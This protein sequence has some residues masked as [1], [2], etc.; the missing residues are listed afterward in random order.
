[1]RAFLQTLIGLSFFISGLVF[2]L[3]ESSVLRQNLEEAKHATNA[4]TSAQTE[5]IHTLQKILDLIEQRD[6]SLKEA[7]QYQT[8]IDRFPILSA[9][10]RQTLENKK[11]SHQSVNTSLSITQLEQEIVRVSSQSLAKA[12]L[13]QQEQDLIR[14]INNSVNQLP[15]QLA[16]AKRNL[17]ESNRR[18]RLQKIAASPLAQAHY[19]LIEADVAANKARVSELELAQLSANN[20]LELAKMRASQHQQQLLLLDSNLQQLRNQLNSL[21]QS[22]ALHVLEQ[23]QALEEKSENFP[24]KINQQLSVNRELSRLLNQQANHMAQTATQQRLVANQTQSVHQALSTLNEQAQW[25]GASPLLGEALRAQIARLPDSPPSRQIEN[26]MAELRVQRL[27]Y[28]EQLNQLDSPDSKS[29]IYTTFTKEQQRIGQEQQAIQKDLLNSLLSGSDSLILELTKL[30]VATNQLQ[31]ALSEVKDATH[32]YLFW[33]ADIST[34]TLQYPIQVV[35]DLTRFLSLDT[36]GQIGKALMLLLKS[37]DSVLP[38]V[39]ALLLVVLSVGSRKHY[40]TFQAKAAQR[41]GKVTLDKFTLTLRCVIW[42]IVVALPLPVLWAA[43]GYGLQQAWRLP[44]AVAFG[45][46]ITAALPMLS[47]FMICAAFAHPNGLFIVHFRW[48]AAIVSQVMRYYSLSVGLIVPLIMTFN[49][50]ENIDDRQF[51]TTLGRFCFILICI[52]LTIVTKALRRSG[53]PLYFDRQGSNDNMLNH[54]LWDIMMIVPTAAA[55]ASC[56]GY[57]ATSE[58]LLARAEG[59]VAIWFLL[60]IIYHIIRRWMLIQRRRIEFD[61]ARQK[62]AEMLANRARITVEDDGWIN[63][64]TNDNIEEPVVDLDTISAQSLR[65][66]RSLL[67]LIA[68]LLLIVLWSELNS[69]FAFLENIPL[70]DVS[71]TIQ[72]IETTEVITLGPVLIAILALIV[73]LQLVRNMPALLELALLQHLSLAPGTGYAIITLTKYT[74]MIIGIIVGLS[75]LGIGWAKVQWMVTALGVGL[76][77]GLQQI[78]ANFVSGLILLFEKP[79]RIGDTVTIRNLTGTVSRIKTRATTIIDWDR[80]E[81]II[82]NQAFVNEQF[83]NWSLSDPVTRVVLNIPAPAE[84]NSAFVTTQLLDAAARCQYVL[85]TPPAEAFLVELQQGIQLFELRLFAADIG[86]RMPLRHELHQL[87]LDNFAKYNIELPY[88]PVQIR[89]EQLNKAKSTPTTRKNDDHY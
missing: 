71:A 5:L 82:P 41:V 1:M 78:F 27:Q 89:M 87:I 18:L 61:R 77:F 64:D 4:D 15:D 25:L 55:I 69:A 11:N 53:L 17:Y 43:L 36:F 79:I 68:L 54:L 23:T 65:L 51:S 2:A 14:D 39:A 31:T 16:Q 70:W 22:E 50:L 49:T 59:S 6:I 67:A 8:V 57:L 28:E 75:M 62:R 45:D 13:A 66:V 44:T 35:K 83:V 37:K 19:W 74:L 48:P 40:H 12:R 29:A 46:G 73:T 47:I 52:S 72:G 86:H 60:L 24:P 33:T 26:Q 84:V 30:K 38:V 21:R 32:R 81:V 76:G 42:S 56:F 9:T 85:K 34:I 10:L 58:A 7:R 63:S 80:K 3:P 20:R 88:P